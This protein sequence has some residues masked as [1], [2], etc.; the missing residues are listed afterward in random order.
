[1][2]YDLLI[3]SIIKEHLLALSNYQVYYFRTGQESNPR[4]ARLV[5]TLLPT[6]I[7]CPTDNSQVADWLSHVFFTLTI[8]NSLPIN[9]IHVKRM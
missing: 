4:L 8:C 7:P 9:N 2:F 1:M 3:E 5:L 6:M